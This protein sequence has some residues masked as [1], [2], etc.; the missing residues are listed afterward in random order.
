MKLNTADFFLLED[1]LHYVTF[2]SE[3]LWQK[4][5]CLTQTPSKQLQ[6]QHSVT[7]YVYI[8]IGKWDPFKVQCL[9]L[10]EPLLSYVGKLP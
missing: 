9:C 2:Y 6:R 3:R 10:E 8:I 7:I 4:P 1:C 5:N